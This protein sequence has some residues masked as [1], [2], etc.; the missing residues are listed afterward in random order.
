[1][2]T[3]NL[4]TARYFGSGTPVLI[5]HGWEMDSSVEALEFEPIFN[6]LSGFRRIYVDLP[7]MGS[8]PAGNI[9]NLDDIQLRLNHFVDTVISTSKFLVIGTS[10]GGYHA[11]AL[12]SKYRKQVDGLLLRVPL[13]EPDNRKRDLDEF[14]TLV[15]N[16]GVMAGLSPSDRDL[17]GD[18]PIQTPEYISALKAKL[19][20]SI[21]PAERASDTA[22]LGPIRTDPQRYRLSSQ[23]DAGS[24]K[25]TAP[26]LILCG[27]HDK[28]V[29]YRDGLR[30][31]ELYP[32][33]TFI[34]LD[35]GTHSWP[36]VDKDIFEVLVSNWLI[37][38][39]QWQAS[40]ASA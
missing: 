23:F 4:L 33:S 6:S 19:N 25:F 9:Q 17:L 24:E 7:G 26:T 29:G 3:E 11:R 16:A 37:R 13:V 31:L 10:C 14:Q 5:V 35:G 36:V 12:A 2:S 22:V 39:K 15:P 34:V 8:T 1:M 32:R 27:R 21:L 30:L 38:V 18:V 20:N 28:V 40:Q